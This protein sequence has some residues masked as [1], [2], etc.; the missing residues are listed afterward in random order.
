MQPEKGGGEHRGEHRR[1][2]DGDEESGQA[3]L[4]DTQVTHEDK[5]QPLVLRSQDGLFLRCWRL[6]LCV[7]AELCA[8]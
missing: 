6:L 7:A 3:E 4:G 5:Y 8:P 1:D 2:Q